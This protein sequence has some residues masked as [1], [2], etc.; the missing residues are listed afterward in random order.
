MTGDAIDDNAVGANLNE[1]DFAVVLHVEGS[2][3]S[4][5]VN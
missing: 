4:S 5:D 3:V 1:Q 2:N